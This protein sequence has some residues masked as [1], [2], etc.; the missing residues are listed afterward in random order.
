VPLPHAGTDPRRER[1]LKG[2]CSFPFYGE[3]R[4]R[5]SLFGIPVAGQVF[6]T[7]RARRIVDKLR[8]SQFAN[9]TWHP[10]PRPKASP[11]QP[12]RS[13]PR[14]RL[15]GKQLDL[16]QSTRSRT[17]RICN[18]ALVD[19]TD[20]TEEH[21][22]LQRPRCPRQEPKKS[23][24]WRAFLRI[25]LPGANCG[26]AWWRTQ[27]YA[28]RSLDEFPAIRENKREFSKI[29]AFGSQSSRHFGENSKDY[30][31]FPTFLS[32]EFQTTSGNFYSRSGKALCKFAFG[33]VAWR[34]IA[35]NRRDHVIEP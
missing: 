7:D 12:A 10:R 22:S 15:V 9:H 25:S 30:F 8:D 26:N 34:G 13:A 2:D 35:A 4:H 28:N 20:S 6:A 1:Q 33:Q 24:V 32:R 27:P 18:G 19:W 3:R 17:I 14:I 23:R 21:S 29:V 5:C 11:I 31:E 16:P